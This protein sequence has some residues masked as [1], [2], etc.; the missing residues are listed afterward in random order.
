[1]SEREEIVTVSFCLPRHLL[2]TVE[3]VRKH[4]GDVTRSATLRLLLLTGLA[5][6]SYLPPEVKKALGLR[7]G[8]RP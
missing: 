2:E 1:M 3:K 8:S 5:E 4:R 7:E 6:L